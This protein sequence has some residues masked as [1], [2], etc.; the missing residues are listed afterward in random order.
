MASSERSQLFRGNF[1]AVLDKI[2][3]DIKGEFDSEPDYNIFFFLKTRIKSHGD[4]ITVFSNKKM[5]R[6]TL[7][8]LV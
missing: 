2:N 1:H 4:E 6:S 5:L 3:A 7:I 8:I